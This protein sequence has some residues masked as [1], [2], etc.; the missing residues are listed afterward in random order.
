MSRTIYGR[1][2]YGIDRRR[3]YKRMERNLKLLIVSRERCQNKFGM[4][5]TDNF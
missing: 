5:S 4:A 3:R 1:K 2:K